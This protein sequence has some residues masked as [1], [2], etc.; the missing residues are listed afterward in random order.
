MFGK[1]SKKILRRL[2]DEPIPAE[3]DRLRAYFAQ[4]DR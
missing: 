3:F 2:D 4:R 1:P